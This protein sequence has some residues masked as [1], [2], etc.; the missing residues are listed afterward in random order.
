MI[1]SL[2]FLLPTHQE[3]AI[4]QIQIQKMI[5]MMMMMILVASPLVLASLII[6]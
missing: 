5:M 2:W 3:E 6:C 1:G 4:L